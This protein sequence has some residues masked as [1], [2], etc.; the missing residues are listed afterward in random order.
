[1]KILPTGGKDLKIFLISLVIMLVLKI[2]DFFKVSS[3]GEFIG[4][5]LYVLLY[6]FLVMVLIRIGIWAFKKIS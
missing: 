2:E 6:S 5:L 1:M 4:W 3:T